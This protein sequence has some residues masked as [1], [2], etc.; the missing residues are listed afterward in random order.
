MV[1]VR[2]KRS[3]FPGS[4]EVATFTFDCDGIQEPGGDSAPESVDELVVPLPADLVGPLTVHARLNY[5]KFDQ[6]LLNFLFTEEAGLAAAVT[7]MSS[8]TA[9]IE[10]VAGAR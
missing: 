9:T 3:L 6:Y 1:G 7:E 4:E 2:F 5:R 8:D 10:L